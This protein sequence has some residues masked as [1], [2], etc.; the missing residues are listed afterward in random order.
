MAVSEHIDIYG[1]WYFVRKIHIN[2]R[3]IVA[4]PKDPDVATDVYE[5]LKIIARYCL[6]EN[7]DHIPASCLTAAEEKAQE[8]SRKSLHKDD[9]VLYSQQHAKL[10][11]YA[12]R[13]VRA[14]FLLAVNPTELCVAVDSLL[15]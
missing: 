4:K 14:F 12:L 11:S 2:G 5:T 7:K 10:I 13:M 15:A 6:Q 3:I 8:N 1:L 9:F